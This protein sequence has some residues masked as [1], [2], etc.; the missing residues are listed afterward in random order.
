MLHPKH[1]RAALTAHSVLR[2]YS[3]FDEKF[4]QQILAKKSM[5][6]MSGLFMLI[7]TFNESWGKVKM[8]LETDMKGK[9]TDIQRFT[10]HGFETANQKEFDCVIENGFVKRTGN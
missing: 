10:G 8:K 5:P 7:F 9:D 2:L 3:G 1:Q 4:Q 6:R